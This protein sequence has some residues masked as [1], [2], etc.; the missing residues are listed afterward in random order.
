[1]NRLGPE[2]G[3][4]FDRTD[5][6]WAGIDYTYVWLGL[7]L[8]PI[9]E[10]RRALVTVM[11]LDPLIGARLD[12]PRCRYH[13]V[14]P[15][16]RAA[17]AEELVTDALPDGLRPETAL[18]Q[19]ELDLGS[20]PFLLFVGERDLVVRFAHAFGDA[21]SCNTLIKHLLA[22]AR[23]DERLPLPWDTLAPVRRDV[24]ALRWVLQRPRALLAALRHRGELSGGTYELASLRTLQEPLDHVATTSP[25][26]FVQHL[27]A[28]RKRR[29]FETSTAAIMLTGIRRHLTARGLPPLPGA[30]M[31]FDTRGGSKVTARAFGNWAAG[32][33]VNPTDD[34][35]LQAV[36][37]E[38]R[39]VRDAGFP[40]LA[41]AAARR[42]AGLQSRGDKLVLAP[43]G[44]PRLTLTHLNRGGPQL[45][46]PW[47]ADNA[48][49]HVLSG[50]A[51]N[52][53]ET[54]LIGGREMEDGRLGLSLSFHPAG[55]PSDVIRSVVEAFMDDPFGDS[56][57]QGSA[58][59]EAIA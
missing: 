16:D 52:G 46:M 20:R 13:P 35:D 21:W 19:F 47:L 24:F 42:R 54:I 31:L 29:G 43:L 1:M 30:E 9:A 32:V 34:D 44:R 26:G 37:A 11:D 50:C 38:F 40:F 3:R 14:A 18:N 6:A 33:Y 4:R 49:H 8:P 45:G 55:W 58:S 39:R 56:L 5:A 25:A 23:T 36:G 53:L 48:D 17:R 28:E 12:L 57:G 27:S 10:L 22:Q 41:A 51:P 2:A 7:D 15:A 59:S